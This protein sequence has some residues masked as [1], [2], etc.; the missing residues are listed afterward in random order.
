ML[1]FD[2]SVPSNLI[3]LDKCPG[4][5]STQTVNRVKPFHAGHFLVYL[6]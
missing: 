3:E 6:L 2:G 5:A 1:T 4:R